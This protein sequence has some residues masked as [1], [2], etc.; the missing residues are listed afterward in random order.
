MK[1]TFIVTAAAGPYVAGVRNPG[2]DKPLSL[3][4]SQAE[5]ALR[6]GH[7]RLPTDHDGDGKPG[8]ARTR[9]K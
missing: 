7:L 2:V 8:G 6:L 1:K 5:H 4:E 3:T 9:G